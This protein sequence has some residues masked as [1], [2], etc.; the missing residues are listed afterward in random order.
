MRS[1]PSTRGKS[2]AVSADQS[3]KS[4]PTT[5]LQS[6]RRFNDTPSYGQEWISQKRVDFG[7]QRIIAVRSLAL[8]LRN[9]I[10]VRLIGLSKR[11]QLATSR[12]GYVALPAR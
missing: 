4:K 7:R 5:A 9:L 1:R 11:L 2:H 3:R 10:T 8:S 6:C 12:L